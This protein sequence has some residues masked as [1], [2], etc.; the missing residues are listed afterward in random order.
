MNYVANRDSLQGY[1]CFV[2][3]G[4]RHIRGYSSNAYADYWLYGDKWLKTYERTSTYSQDYSA[5]TCLDIDNLPSE[6][7]NYTPI[8][9]F[10]GLIMAVCTYIF[11]YKIMIKWILKNA[12]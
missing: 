2:Y 6:V 10:I 12:I 3:M 11:I 4:E 1:S 7:A 9:T 8:Y 5:Y